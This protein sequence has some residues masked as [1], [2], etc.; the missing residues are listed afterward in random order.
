MNKALDMLVHGGMNNLDDYKKS[1]GITLSFSG[2]TN[3]KK[4]YIVGNKASIKIR[5]KILEWGAFKELY[6]DKLGNAGT[7]AL[8][9]VAARIL[10]HTESLDLDQT[11]ET[12]RI[13]YKLPDVKLSQMILRRFNLGEVTKNSIHS[14]FV[15]WAKYLEKSILK[16]AEIR[17]A[18][19]DHNQTHNQNGN[20][21]VNNI[22]DLLKNWS[23]ID[24]YYDIETS[25]PLLLYSHFPKK[26]YD[27]PWLRGAFIEDDLWDIYPNKFHW[28]ITGVPETELLQNT[29]TNS[30]FLY[31]GFCP[32]APKERLRRLFSFPIE[33]LHAATKALGGDIDTTPLPL[34]EII[35]MINQSGPRAPTSFEPPT[36]LRELEPDGDVEHKVKWYVEK[37]IDIYL[38]MKPHFESIETYYVNLA[39]NLSLVGFKLENI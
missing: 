12:L 21:E 35:T 27:L 16:Y 2:G 38:K 4:T 37:F 7:S 31:L 29:L 24:K 11:L 19:I 34:P 10:Y 6:P 36:I 32:R 28:I 9:K 39:K 5:D 13:T 3:N 17:N 15:N 25:S 1:G 18:Y 8:C 22:K 33:E 20:N 30:N 23:V 14:I 26:P